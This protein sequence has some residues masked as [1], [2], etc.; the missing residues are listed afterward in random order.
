MHL[1]APPQCGRQWQC[2]RSTHSCRAGG[3]SS[4]IPSPAFPPFPGPP[5]PLFARARRSADARIHAAT[6][7]AVR[8]RANG[9]N[10]APGQTLP[11]LRGSFSGRALRCAPTHSLT[12][13]CASARARVANPCSARP[14]RARADAQRRAGE[15]VGAQRSTRPLSPPG[16]RLPFRCFSYTPPPARRRVLSCQTTPETEAAPSVMPGT[17]GAAARCRRVGSAAGRRRRCRRGRR[18]CRFGVCGVG[19]S[20]AA[21]R[22]EQKDRVGPTFGTSLPPLLPSVPCAGSRAVC[23]TGRQ[24]P[25]GRQTRTQ[26]QHS[27]LC[28]RRSLQRF[29][30]CDA[31]A[32]LSTFVAAAP[33]IAAAPCRFTWCDAFSAVLDERGVPIPVIAAYA[34]S[35]PRKFGSGFSMPKP[36]LFV[37]GDQNSAIS[38]VRCHAPT[39]RRP[40]PPSRS[41]DPP[42][43]V[44]PP[45]LRH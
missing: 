6:P 18:R 43:Q 4:S 27:A 24:Y 40:R 32:Q 1:P 13:P 42:P 14:G 31:L 41:H 2:G 38:I 34:R 11:P 30:S 7:A 17:R 20:S 25:T 15:C 22:E 37:P 9:C 23:C 8:A 19:M 36:L 3:L 16:T 45:P 21:G 5:F 44:P 33:C 35:S 28:C 12:R 29:T 10:S 39:D 26:P